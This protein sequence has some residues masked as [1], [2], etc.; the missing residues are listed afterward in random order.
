MRDT[1]LS[2]SGGL[3]SSSLL[4]EFKERIAL[5]VSFKYPSNHN[6]REL[7]RASEVAKRAGVDHHVVDLT[8]AFVGFKSALLSGASKVPNAE[9]DKKSIEE[10]V[11]PFRN[12]IF[13]SV[14]AGLAESMGCEF[15]A[16][17]N[18]GG[19]HE[20]YPDCRP[21]F[22]TAMGLAIY[23]GTSNGVQLFCPYV[24]LDKGEIAYRG[25]KAGLVPE[26]TYSCYKGKKQPCG[27]CPTCVERQKALDYACKKL[28]KE[29]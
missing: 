22:A 7:K 8:G 2:L 17:A 29:K 23:K 14:L 1:I 16:L 4:F 10:L 18:H 6:E 5:A 15:I 20:I 26:W 21:E 11:V 12:G 24:N 25:I 3:D 9:Y 27:K 13:L 19:D 28:N